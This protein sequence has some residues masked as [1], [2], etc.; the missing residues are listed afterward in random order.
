MCIREAISVVSILIACCYGVAKFVAQNNL[1]I[2]REQGL[3]CRCKCKISIGKIQY[4]S[5]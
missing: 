4:N 2:Y 3:F 5:L 1:P